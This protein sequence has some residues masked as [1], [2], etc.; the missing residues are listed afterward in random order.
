MTEVL[1]QT[2]SPKRSVCSKP[3][4]DC[5][6]ERLRALEPQPLP[7]AARTKVH[8]SDLERAGPARIVGNPGRVLI[9]RM[10]A[11]AGKTDSLCSLRTFQLL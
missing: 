7:K 6:Q 10:S 4:Q 1:G 2:K 3:I 11:F 9:I 8:R 5:Q